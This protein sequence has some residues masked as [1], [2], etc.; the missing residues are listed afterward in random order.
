MVGKKIQPDSEYSRGDTIIENDV[1]IGY[2][3]TIMP[4]VKV[5]NGAIIAAHAV[6]TKDVEPYTIV[7]GNP[8]KII[9]QRFPNPVIEQLQKLCW[10]DWEASKITAHLEVLA[11]GNIDQL[12]E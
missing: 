10:W 12:R 1:W 6:V 7:G 8:A 4:G 3:A 2:K 9:R 11:S 5:G